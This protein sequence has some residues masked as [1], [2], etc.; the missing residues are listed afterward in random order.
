V[1]GFSAVVGPVIGGAITQGIAWPWVF[2]VNVPIGLLAI[3]FVRTRV[4][5]SF[6]PKAKLDFPGL[7]LVTGAALGL[8][9]GL[10][11]SNAAGWGSLEVVGTLAG[12]AALTAAL[13]AW[14]LR[15]SAPM[16]PMRLFRSRAFSAGNAAIFFL[17][18]SLAGAVFFMAQFQQ[19]SLG[20]GPLAA[21]LRLLPW[22]LAPFLIAPR[23]GALVDR[24]GGRP[25]IVA[26]LLL[27]TIGMGWIALVASPSVSYVSVAVPMTLSGA[28]FALAIPALTKTVVSSVALADIGKASGMF[29]TMRQLGGAF[30]VAILVAVF[31]GSGGY[32]TAQA[33]SDG[34]VPAIAVSA[35]LALAGAVAG[36]VLRGERAPGPLVVPVA[37]REAA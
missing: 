33:F 37:A 16:L 6:G 29:S 17:N 8:V 27:Q 12:G 19:V 31:A 13:V 4:E 7:G 20:Q 34:F 5:E 28:G 23:A 3:A 10:V 1:T 15:A 25:L 11:R 35:A 36:T 22:G 26:G 32:G 21:G 24:I 30:G 9:W 18:A 2:W 14:E